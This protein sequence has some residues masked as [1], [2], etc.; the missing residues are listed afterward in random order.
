M[1][2]KAKNKAMESEPS[3]AQTVRTEPYFFSGEGA[4][5]PVTIH[6]ENISQATEEWERIKEPNS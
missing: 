2:D 4:W 6:A 3:H 5:K 1:I